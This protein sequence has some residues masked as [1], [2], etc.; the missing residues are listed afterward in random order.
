MACRAYS[1]W[2][3][4][5]RLQAGCGQMMEMERRASGAACVPRQ[6][7]ATGPMR[8]GTGKGGRPCVG[9]TRAD[10]G[11]AAVTCIDALS[12][13]GHCPSTNPIARRA[14]APVAR[15]GGQDLPWQVIAGVRWQA[16]NGGV[17]CHAL[18]GQRDVGSWR[19]GLWMPALML[20]QRQ[21]IGCDA[22]P[23]PAQAGK[24]RS[25]ESVDA[26]FQAQ[27]AGAGLYG[28]GRLR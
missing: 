17:C 19:M 16:S 12:G 11:S 27:R 8:S 2:H 4:A 7:R 18:A 1:G 15:A 21:G 20:A 5:G 9:C 28:P 3:V 24:Q 13:I 6:G 26:N 22:R 14:T 10:A 23:L 25:K